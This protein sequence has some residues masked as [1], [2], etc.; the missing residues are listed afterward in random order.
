MAKYLS[1]RFV[2]RNGSSGVII[3]W[4]KHFTSVGGFDE[5]LEL[6]ENSELIRRL[7]RFGGYRY[8]GEPPPRPPCALRSAR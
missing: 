7:K 3:C 6:R 4:K 5:R 8:I 2:V 1:H